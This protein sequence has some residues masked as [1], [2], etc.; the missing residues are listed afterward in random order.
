MQWRERRRRVLRTNCAQDR[1]SCRDRLS[2]QCQSLPGE[3][4]QNA[5]RPFDQTTTLVGNISQDNFF[6]NLDDSST[7]LSRC[8]ACF[9]FPA[10]LGF[11]IYDTR[12]RPESNAAKPFPAFFDSTHRWQARADQGRAHGC[13]PSQRQPDDCLRG[14][15]GIS[16]HRYCSNH[17]IANG[18]IAAR[19]M[20]RTKK[21]ER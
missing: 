5:F 4:L 8:G 2:Q 17:R 12:S 15:G 16:N 21:K 3:N 19:R 1:R 18:V 11:R 20:H 10:L 13:G 6:N 9:R 14:Q 7:L